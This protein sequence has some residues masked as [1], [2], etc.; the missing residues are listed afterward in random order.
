MRRSAASSVPI[1]A[2]VLLALVLGTFPAHVAAEGT[3]AIAFESDRTG[4]SEIYLMHANRTVLTR[5]T[6]NNVSDASPALSRDGTTVAFIQYATPPVVIVQDIPDGEAHVV[7]LPVHE[8]SLSDPCFFMDP[9]E[10]RLRLAAMFGDYDNSSIGRTTGGTD[11]P[12]GFGPSEIWVMDLDGTN[13]T[14]VN[15]TAGMHARH[16][17]VSPDGQRIA[18]EA[19]WNDSRKLFVM[20]MDGTMRRRLTSGDTDETS[21]SWSPD[22]SRI[23]FVSEWDG[24]TAIA[25][26]RTDGTDQRDLTSTPDLNDNPAWSP[27]GTMIAFDSNRD[28][29]SEIYAIFI[30]GTGLMQLTDDPG[31]DWHPSWGEDAAQIVAIPG[32]AGVP[33]DLDGDG[34]CEDVNGN[35]RKDF[36]DVTLYFNQ[37]AWIGENEPLAAFDYNGNGRIDFADVTW[38]FRNL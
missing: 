38:L 12:A 37:M 5:L 11:A 25:M 20:N 35:G 28:G 21:P 27:D 3:S 2:L 4:G 19:D 15:N 6:T 32:G 30:D 14:P 1:A 34:K 24:G 10:R 17:T 31:N 7:T 8:S 36:A 33:R 26:V 13:A 23:A 9:K 18:F 22:G 29:D 16:P